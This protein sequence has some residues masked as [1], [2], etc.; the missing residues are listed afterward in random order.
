MVLHET[1]DIRR[2]STGA[3]PFFADEL[4]F[5]RTD[6]RGVIQA[7]NCV[8][9]RV[10]AY[11]WDEMLGA[12]HKLIRHADMPRAVFW[13]LW[14][15]IKKGQPIGA[16]VK[17]RAKD[18][19][20]YWVFAIVSPVPGGYLSVRLKP[21][22]DLLDLVETEYAGLVALE[23]TEGISPSDSAQALLA[24]L[25]ELGFPTYDSFLTHALSKELT[26]RASVLKQPAPDWLEQFAKIDQA[27]SDV[28]KE[29]RELATIFESIRGI[30]YNM[31]ILASRLEA[32]GGP[33]SV[34]SANYGVLSEEIADW[35]R[36]FG[37]DNDGVFSEIRQA[38]EHALLLQSIASV[39]VEMISQFHSETGLHAHMDVVGETKTLTQNAQSFCDEAELGL[40]QVM[41]QVERFSQSVR[42]MKRF[43][44]GLGATRM[45]CKIEGA[46][47][48]DSGDSLAGVISELDQFQDR[49]EDKLSRIDDFNRTIQQNAQSLIGEP[50]RD[51]SID[52]AIATAAE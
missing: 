46:R 28:A 12:P 32:A 30:P 35:M 8:F 24:R 18:G 23:N 37:E 42:D 6:E 52:P 9:Q 34:I 2:P 14:D 20:F 27:V 49:I 25:D 50:P 1:R 13:L 7:G 47:L 26:H 40:R 10:A 3:A 41:L 5:S 43:I 44:T 38:V 39:Q 31:R 17:N 36:S 22:S 33:I 48:R 16:Y 4:F 45:M 19:L 11:D 51:T 21:T 15:T 29:T